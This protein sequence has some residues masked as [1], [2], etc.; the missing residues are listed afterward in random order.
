[1]NLDELAKVVNQIVL[2]LFLTLTN[3]SEDCLV[4]LAKA[5]PIIDVNIEEQSCHTAV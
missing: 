3:L 5:E 4:L 1:M 2:T